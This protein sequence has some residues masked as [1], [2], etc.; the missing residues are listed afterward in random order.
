MGR[1]YGIRYGP[2]LIDLDI[3]FYEKHTVY[4]D[5]LTVP[6]ECIWEKP[7]VLAPLIDLLGSSLE[8][9]TVASWHSFSKLPGGL[10]EAWEKLSGESLIDKDDMSRVLP[11][12][13]SLWDWSKRTAVMGV[14]N[15]TPD[16]FSYGRKYHTVVDNAV[17]HVHQMISHGTDIIDLEASKDIAGSEGKLLS[18]NTFYAKVAVEVVRK[19]EHIVNDVSAGT[20]DPKTLSAV[21]GLDV[22]YIALH[23]RGDLATMQSADN[24]QYHDNI[25]GQV[26]SELNL[27]NRDAESTG[28]PC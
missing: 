19:G 11:V 24:L 18:A 12:G 8:T 1:T 23:M 22:P 14:L 13:N 5:D 6:H 28:I 20:L 15:L 26:A 4:S 21:A 3:L 25:C 16:S 10:F 9:D 7:F 27:R 2:R 17:A